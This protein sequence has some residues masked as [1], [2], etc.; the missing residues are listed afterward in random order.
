MPGIYALMDPAA[1]EMMEKIG[2]FVS[3]ARRILWVA[4]KRTT[5]PI[6]LTFQWSSNSERAVVARGP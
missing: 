1:E 2:V 6:V 3:D 4:W 5:G